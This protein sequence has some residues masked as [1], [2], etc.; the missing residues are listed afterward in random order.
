MANYL[1]AASGLAQGLSSLFKG[2]TLGKFLKWIFV[3]LSIA[4]VVLYVYEN[5][6]SQDYFYDKL[7]RK[8]EIIAKIQKI[9]PSDSLIVLE[10]NK[11]LLEILKDIDPPK[12]QEINVPA[13]KTFISNF[14]WPIL[15]KFFSAWIFP[16]LIVLLNLGDKGIKD[17]IVGAFSLSIF[18]GIIAVFVPVIYNNVWWHFIM[19]P[20]AELLVL[21]LYLVIQKRREVKNLV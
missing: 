7:D 14:S 2:L 12:N 15:L 10:S 3:L 4:I 8:I 5:F 19:T 16:F 11:R 17:M 13:I 21:L 18:F 20:L 9:N 1:E 6:F